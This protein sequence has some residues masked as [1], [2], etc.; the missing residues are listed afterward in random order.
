MT[1]NAVTPSAGADLA[2]AVALAELVERADGVSHEVTRY[3]PATG[4][5]EPDS[6]LRAEVT[7]VAR[8][9]LEYGDAT[10]AAA[11]ALRSSANGRPGAL[12][13]HEAAALALGDSN[14]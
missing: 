4:R 3:P 6:G 13:G 8:V 14:G 1:P 2:E 11:P 9:A 10:R 5:A 7:N 12:S